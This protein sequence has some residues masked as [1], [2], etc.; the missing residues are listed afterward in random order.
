MVKVLAGRKYRYKK[1][2]QG[3]KE[4]WKRLNEGWIGVVFYC[5]LGIGVAFSVHQISGV[6]LGTGLPIVTVSSGSMI[7]TLNIGD[8]VIIEGQE[9]YNLGDIIV[10]KGWESEPII[11]RIVAISDGDKV[12]KLKG[13]DELTDRYI[14]EMAYGKGKIYITKGDN[15][16]RCDQCAGRYPVEESKVYGKA[17]AKIPCM[18]WVKILFVEWFIRDPIFGIII[19]I[20]ISTVYFAYKKTTGE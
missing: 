7:P 1:K 11:H 9:T 16:P 20:V 5:I 13:W 14:E 12:D 19:V 3:V 2:P 6:A 10:F 17:V 4:V 18:G 8:I 15:N